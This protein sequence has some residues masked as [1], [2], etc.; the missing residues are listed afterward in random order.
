[1]QVVRER[2]DRS[3]VEAGSL[4]PSAQAC[5][6][7]TEPDVALL[8]QRFVVVWQVIGDREVAAGTHEARSG[9]DRIRGTSGV[10]EDTRHHHEIGT[11]ALADVLDET[12]VVGVAFA[13]PDVR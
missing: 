5:R 13:Q 10:V 4:E 9:D 1:M 6:W 11:A 3:D 2:M 8:A 12:G 7:K